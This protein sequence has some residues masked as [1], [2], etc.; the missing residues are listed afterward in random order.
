[1]SVEDTR[2]LAKLGSWEDV[3]LLSDAYIRRSRGPTATTGVA[4]GSEEG[5]HECDNSTWS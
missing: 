4:S 1:M 2:Y 3:S 5:G